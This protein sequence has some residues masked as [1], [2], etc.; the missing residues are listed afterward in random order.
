MKIREFIEKC[1]GANRFTFV[2]VTGKIKTTSVTFDG[3]FIFGVSPDDAIL[4][5]EVRD[6][7]ATPNG[8]VTIT[9]ESN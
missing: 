8:N 6:W 9:Y 1:A 2:D 3:Y 4:D 5:A 7:E